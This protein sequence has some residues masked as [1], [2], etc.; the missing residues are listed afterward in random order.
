MSI[1][2]QF[3]SIELNTDVDAS[4]YSFAS[5]LNAVIGSYGT[6]KSSL[7]ELIKFAL[8][9]RKAKIMPTVRQRL[10]SVVLDVTLGQNRVLLTRNIGENRISVHHENGTSERWSAAGGN[11][12]PAGGR[13]LE[14]LGLPMV[15]LSK[16][17]LE[18]GEPLTFFDL[19]RFIYLPQSDVNLSVAGH[20]ETMLL[21]KRKA[22]F[23]LAYGLSSEQIREL[24]L[25]ISALEA[26]RDDMRSAA[27]A[28]ERFLGEIG[29]PQESELHAA[30]IEARAALAEAETRLQ[31]VKAGAYAALPGDQEALRS[32]IS[33]LRIAA[34]D[35]EAARSVTVAAVRRG[36]SLIAQ[37]DVDIN[38]E[39]RADA[40][41][42]AL[43]GLEFVTCPRCLQSISDRDVPA[44]HCLLC[45]QI[46]SSSTT[47]GHQRE[48]ERLTA[49]RDEA[50][51]LL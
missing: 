2:L 15:R 5:G 12:P 47:V 25:E 33:T 37:L 36:E 34:A 50:V 42:T 18:K 10:R 8:G 4:T 14:M 49:Q 23:E 46:Q 11:L 40:A 27:N 26:K 16:K 19:Y 32:R 21:R 51:A 35:T 7:F 43:S 45:T 24:L 9:A 3:H 31:A 20:A 29:A 41:S 39:V 30:E 22:I 13:L 28:V 38:R 1:H 6:G 44:G 17:G 48:I